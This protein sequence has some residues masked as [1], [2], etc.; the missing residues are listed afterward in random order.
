MTQG[1]GIYSQSAYGP[2]W[3]HLRNPQAKFQEDTACAKNCG[4]GICSLFLRNCCRPSMKNLKKEVP[5]HP[6]S[7][8]EQESFRRINEG[9][10]YS[11][12][13]QGTA[14]AAPESAISS[15]KDKLTRILESRLFSHYFRREAEHQGNVVRC[16]NSLAKALDS[17]KERQSDELSATAHR[18]E[19]EFS[20]KLNELKA[21]YDQKLAELGAGMQQ[22]RSQL[23][24]LDSVSRGLEQIV[25]RISSKR[26]TPATASDASATDQPESAEE[27]TTYDYLLLENR[28]RGSE[29]EI[30]ERLREY[31]E[32]FAKSDLSKKSGKVFEI[33]AGRG[34]L[35]T[36]FAERGISSYGMDLDAAMVEVCREKG[37]DVSLGDALSHLSD[38]P[39]HSLAGVIAIQ[40]VEHL[41][42]DQLRALFE[43]CAKK[44]VQGGLVVFETINTESLLAL[45]HNY[46][47][48]PTH[49]WPL[50]PETLRYLM[51]LHGLKVIEVKRRSPYPESACL[52]EVELSPELPPR[53]HATV[54][55][56]NHNTRIL[57]SLIY[58]YQDYCIIAEVPNR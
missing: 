36:L 45:G 34:E 51:D 17:R 29:S 9:Y 20:R 13:Q 52:Q 6:S 37:L 18:L 41:T 56:I 43:N 38:C 5:G 10:S 44:V 32:L 48:D 26:P 42:L 23:E 57:N 22:H 8:M 7:F 19:I 46:F 31:P 2:T 33:G 39:E 27:T 4:R 25:S 15:W 11:L 50:H 49:I 28:Y 1:K 58:G 30:R 21:N 55:S 40:V 47:R 16:I 12:E 54:A 53:W 35:Q 24:T 14:P 3:K